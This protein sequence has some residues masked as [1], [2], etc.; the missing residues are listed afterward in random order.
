[1]ATGT[2]VHTILA[3]KDVTLLILFYTATPVYYLSHCLSVSNYCPDTVL[4]K[5]NSCLL[6]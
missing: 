2:H 4:L 6:C 3:T 1:M 5:S